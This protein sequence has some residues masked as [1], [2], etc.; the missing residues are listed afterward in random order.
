MEDGHSDP[1]TTDAHEEEAAD[2]QRSPA[3]ALNGEALKDGSCVSAMTGMGGVCLVF[4]HPQHPCDDLNGAGPHC[5]V[6]NVRFWDPSV[7]ENVVCVEP[8]LESQRRRP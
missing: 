1:R 8:D 4:T 3:H 5:C 6:L 7:P 2:D